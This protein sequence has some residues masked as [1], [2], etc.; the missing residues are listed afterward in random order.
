MYEPFPFDLLVRSTRRR[1][2]LF[3]RHPDK[4]P[5]RDC[6]A[7]CGAHGG[8]LHRFCL[9]SY[10]IDQPESPA[11]ANRHCAPREGATRITCSERRRAICDKANAHE[12]FWAH[13][14]IL[15]RSER[16]WRGRELLPSESRLK[17]LA[18]PT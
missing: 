7:N 5:R 16:H 18:I 15:V 17:G 6:S 10:R 11:T 3:Q 12:T 1:S 9:L 8:S 4:G 2:I 14:P 13:P